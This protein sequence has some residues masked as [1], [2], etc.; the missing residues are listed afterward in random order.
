[1]TVIAHVSDIHF[2]RQRTGVAE[3]LLLDL[4][5]ATPDIIVI[6]GDLTQTA[7]HDQFAAA[8]AFLARLKSPYL[9]VPGNHDI[10]A[11]PLTERFLAPLR[12]WR[13]HVAEG[14]APEWTDGRV[15]IK[16]I[17]SARPFGPYLNWSRGRI[18]PVQLAAVASAELDPR[19]LVATAH[20]PV[21]FGNDSQQ[22]YDLMTR[23]EEL[24]QVLAARQQSI[25]LLGHRHRAHV[26]LWNARTGER[27]AAAE[28]GVATNDVVILH[29]G[30]AASDRLRGEVNSWNRIELDSGAATVD[31]R[32]LT[33]DG[34]AVG[35]RFVMRWVPVG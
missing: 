15:L 32:R 7:S 8:S 30:T 19:I 16:G 27:P 4:E 18:S 31:I 35:E 26:S 2:G 34:W 21:A 11:F 29:A 28:D 24:L 22:A 25:L 10:P 13:R 9:V 23:G 12:R 6:S 1:M 20:H 3:G 5:A 33:P 17:N 14:V